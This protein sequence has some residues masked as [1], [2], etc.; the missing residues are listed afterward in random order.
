MRFAR[1]GH[2]QP[3]A[4]RLRAEARSSSVPIAARPSKQERVRR[5]R[6]ADVLAHHGDRRAGVAA[7]VRVDEAL[8]QPALVRGEAAPRSASP[9]SCGSSSCSVAR[10]RCSALLAAATVMSSS[11]AVSRAVQSSTSRMISTAR[12]RG[13]S[14]WIDGDEGEL[15]RLALDDDGLG[16]LARAAPSRRAAGP[17]RAAARARRGTTRAPARAANCAGSRRGRRSSRS[18]TARRGSSG[19]PSKRVEVAPGAEVGLLHHVL[20]GLERAEHP[21]AVNVQLAPVGLR[22]LREGGLVAA[23]R[24]GD[25][26]FARG[27]GAVTSPQVDVGDRSRDCPTP[28]R[29]RGTRPSRRPRPAAERA[30]AASS[31]RSCG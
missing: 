7:L 15:D 25:E 23:A 27:H 28:G 1:V 29:T 6:D 21:V 11:S 2:E 10:A 3:I 12:W 24:G 18:C 26:P 17:G 13:G 5:H 30:A 20:G 14:A 4:R 22:E 9:R 19:P 8:E 16:L 31:R